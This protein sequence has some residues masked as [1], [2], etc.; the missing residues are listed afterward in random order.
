MVNAENFKTKIKEQNDKIADEISVHIQSILS[1]ELEKDEVKV[2]FS[3]YLN[4]Q[5]SNNQDIVRAVMNTLG[6]RVVECENSTQGLSVKVD[7]SSVQNKRTAEIA[8]NEL[9]E[10]LNRHIGSGNPFDSYLNGDIT[11]RYG[12]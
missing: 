11:K 4:K 10:I 9:N 7:F 1:L 8:Y 12:L 2:P 6:F 5:C 3:M